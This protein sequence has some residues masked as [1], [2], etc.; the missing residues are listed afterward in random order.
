MKTPNPKLQELEN[1]YKRALADYQNLE[2][3]MYQN[4]VLEK[5][6][7]VAKFLP[8]LDDL[9][10]AFKHTQDKGI[11]LIVK[12]FGKTLNDLGVNR[13]VSEPGVDFDPLF[14]EC[15]EMVEGEKDKVVE[16]LQQGYRLADQPMV[17]RPA[18]VT[19][20][21]GVTQSN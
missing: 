18:K 11:E 9:E 17:L 14:M 1:N 13:V 8:L 21:A 15:I 4:S 7:L 12:Q 3:R 10:R 6:R 20:G 19:V 16:V 5:S 2:K